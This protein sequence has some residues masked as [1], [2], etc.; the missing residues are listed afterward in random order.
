MKVANAVLILILIPIFNSIIYPAF[1]KINLLK[2]PLQRIGVGFF[3]AALA[4]G[5]S[6]ILD[7]QLEVDYYQISNFQ[8]IKSYFTENIS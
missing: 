2:T 7:L 6:G 3:M 8:I 5:V 1:A 4:F